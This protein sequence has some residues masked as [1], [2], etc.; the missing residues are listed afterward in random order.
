MN[1]LRCLGSFILLSTSLCLHAQ[2]GKIVIAAGTPEDQALT[3][4]SN[5]SDAQKK[6]S[7]Y[8]DFLQK[9][10]A[11]PAAVAYGNWQISQSYQSAGDLQKALGFGDKAL[12][13]APRDLDILVSQTS[14]AQ[15]MKDDARTLEYSFKGGE[16]YD[17]IEKQPKPEALSDQ[18]FAT[19]VEE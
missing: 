1:R 18:E 9:F 12:E 11:N 17:S 6:L 8:E 19:R 4:I 15:Q 10:S 16:I 3:A 2:V 7:M 13:G 5:E 14:I